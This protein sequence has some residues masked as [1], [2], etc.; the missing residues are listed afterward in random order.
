MTIYPFNKK[1]PGLTAIGPGLLWVYREKAFSLILLLRLVHKL[2]TK[3]D[4]TCPAVKLNQHGLS[5][6][7]SK[8]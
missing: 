4:P 8:G 3:G 1:N 7:T 2:E 5:K 6:S